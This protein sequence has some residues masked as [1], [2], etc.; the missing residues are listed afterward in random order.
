MDARRGPQPRTLQEPTSTML[1]LQ[2]L[3][4]RSCRGKMGLLHLQ[5]LAQADCIQGA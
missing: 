3:S 1:R 2:L 4:S 5:D